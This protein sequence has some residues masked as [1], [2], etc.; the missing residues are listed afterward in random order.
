MGT[1]GNLRRRRLSFV[2]RRRRKS[3]VAAMT[4]IEH[5]HELRRRLIFSL[6]AFV[7]ISIGAFFFFEPILDLLL[8]PLCELDPSL[9][10]PQ[11]CRLSGFGPAEPF[12]VRLKVT[13]M[14]GVVFSA[15]VW[16]YQ[17]WAFVTPGLT[18]QEKKYA[19][20]FILSSIVLFSV[21][22]TFAYL[23]LEPGLRF[24]I[25]LGEGLI[26]PFFRADAYLNFVGLMFIGFGLTFELPLLLFFL[27]LSGAV[28]VQQLQHQR[29]AAFV[30]I[31]ALAA[32]VTPSQD[33]YTMLLMAGPLYVLYEGTIILLRV[34][35]KRKRRAGAGL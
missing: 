21:G 17:I 22:V 29:R 19:L 13:A 30:A 15:P 1:S 24:L 23:T 4:M 34:V 6:A 31:V 18:P 16:I 35:Q 7:A 26:T 2:G 20:P 28:S 32:V 10:G 8:A 9:L 11:G 33:P 3:Q 14:V 12:I 5:L 27:G 25:G